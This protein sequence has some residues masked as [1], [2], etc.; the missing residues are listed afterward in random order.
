MIFKLRILDH[1]AVSEEER[2]QARRWIR[3]D[4]YGPGG[5]SAG[6]GGGGGKEK[7]QE[8]IRARAVASR[9]EMKA[10]EKRRAADDKRVGEEESDGLRVRWMNGTTAY[11]SPG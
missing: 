7:N 2:R 1:A 11:N 10:E 3:A 6:G 5:A 8:E 9:E 4:V